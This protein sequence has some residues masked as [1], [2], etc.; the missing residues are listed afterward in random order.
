[1]SSLAD[2]PN[3]LKTKTNK[4]KRQKV[5]NYKLMDGTGRIPS[6]LVLRRGIVTAQADGQHRG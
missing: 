4:F 2:L 5:K 1:M 3:W 6:V